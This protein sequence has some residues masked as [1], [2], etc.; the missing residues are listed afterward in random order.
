MQSFPFSTLPR[1]P[2]TFNPVLDG[3]T[4]TANIAWSLFGQRWYLSLYDASGNRVTTVAVVESPQFTS[5]ATMAWDEVG[6]VVTLSTQYPHGLP[7]GAVVEQIIRGSTPESYNG[8]WLMSVDSPTELSFPMA[9]DPGAL[10][11][12]GAFGRD[13]DLTA[14]YFQTSTLCYRNETFYAFP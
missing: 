8:T 10:V 1:G 3:K 4:Y 7:V 5:I 12:L 13:I 11:A 2:L 6:Q 9:S 14:G